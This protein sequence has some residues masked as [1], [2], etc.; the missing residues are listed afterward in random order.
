MLQKGGTPFRFTLL[1]EDDAA[2]SYPDEYAAALRKAFR[3]IGVEMAIEALDRRTL[4]SRI[5]LERDFDAYLWWNGYNFDPDPGFYWHSKSSVNNYDNPELD[6][7]I[8]QSATAPRLELRKQFLDGIATRI[9]R[10]AAFIPLYYFTRYVAARN[11]L[12]FPPASA[13]D[14]SNSGVAYDVHT[15]ERTR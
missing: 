13:A 4:Q 8:D 9:A 7:L 6:R 12:K 5:F 3:A 14:F 11:T 15:I 2:D 1:I 10:D